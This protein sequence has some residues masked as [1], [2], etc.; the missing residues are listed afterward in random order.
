MPTVTRARLQEAAIVV[1]LFA[2]TSVWGTIYWN[3]S[4]GAG[5]QPQFY[6]SYFEPAVMF[7]CGR[8]FLLAHPTIPA[9]EDF[10]EQKTDRLSCDDIPR[11]AGLSDYGLY[12]KTWLYLMLTVGLTWKVLGVSWSGMGPLFGVL[13]GATILAAYGI[14]RRGMSRIIADRRAH[15]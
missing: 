12:Q 7:A 6:Q 2:S 4:F 11:T 10:I 8:G 13:F 3:R 1:L 15:V 9:V 5:R 14:F